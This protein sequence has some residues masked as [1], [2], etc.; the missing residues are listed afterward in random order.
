MG[1]KKKKRKKERIL[2]NSINLVKNHI[3]IHRISAIIVLRC[4][5]EFVK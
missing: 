4:G 2:I 1:K 5:N 3:N